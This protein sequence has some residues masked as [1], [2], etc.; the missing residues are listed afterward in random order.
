MHIVLFNLKLNR[1]E[2]RYRRKS[3]RNRYQTGYSVMQIMTA[4]KNDSTKALRPR[5]FK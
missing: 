4:Q 1:K 2:K 5:R 3:V